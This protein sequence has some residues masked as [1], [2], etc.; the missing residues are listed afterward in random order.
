MRSFWLLGLTSIA[1]VKSDA[2]MTQQT[3]TGHDYWSAGIGLSQS[4]G[5]MSWYNAVWDLPQTDYPLADFQ[6]GPADCRHGI[7]APWPIWTDW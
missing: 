5:G 7:T 3:M 2:S 1:R 4:Q 6:V